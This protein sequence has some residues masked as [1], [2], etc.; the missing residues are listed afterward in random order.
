MSL[1]NVINEIRNIVNKALLDLNYDNINYDISEPP[2]SEFGDL[3]VNVAFLLS[4]RLGKSP[5]KIAQELVNE[6]INIQLKNSNNYSF[7]Q[8]AEAHPSGH[9]NFY[10]NYSNFN[11]FILEIIKKERNLF[12]NLGVKSKITIEHTS[13]NPNKAL[14]IGHLR[15]VVLG[16]SLYR[17]FRE[18]NHEVI[19]LNYIDDS[20]VQVADLIVAFN[21]AGFNSES[22]D[23]SIKFD[24]YCGD[25]YVK[26]N[27]LY[28]TNVDL[29]EKRKLVIK[30]IEKG[31]TEISKFTNSIVEKIV[32]QQLLTCWRIKARYDLLVNESQILLSD[33]WKGTFNLLKQKSIIHF[34]TEGKNLNCWLIND[35]NNEEKVIV[36]SDKT[37][38]YIA[39]DISFA[40]WKLKLVK[41]P[42]IYKQ[43]SIQWDNSILWNTILI[44]ANKDGLINKNNELL[45]LKQ[46][47]TLVIT[48]IDSRQSR[49]QK[50]IT[51]I[52]DKVDITSTKKYIYLGYEAVALSNETVQSIGFE[53]EKINK[54]VIHMSGRKGIFINADMILDELYK[55]SYH[56]VK[57]RNPTWN[58]PIIE[59][60]AEGIAVS[61]IRYNLIKQDL[62]K[63]IT[64]DMKEALNL[65]GDTSLY[66][67]YSYVRGI[68]ILEKGNGFLPNFI[69][70]EKNTDIKL[71]LLNHKTEIE[72]IKEISKFYMII[73]EAVSN[74]NPK[75]I[76]KYANKLSTKFNSF[77]ESL[78][79]LCE[80]YFLKINRLL[81]VKVFVV[82]LSALF[83]I[84]G[85]ETLSRI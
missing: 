84:L 4:K 71:N 69:E 82:I 58:D 39:K 22:L 37:A 57:K 8:N 61:A 54:K 85:I 2:K 25:I 62:D 17:L 76:A 74:L 21:F 47:P 79:V 63:M 65:D 41:D 66:L 28:N 1:K 32:K 29:L 33:L 75:I 81:L 14:H 35:E 34:A 70:I 3:T 16:D 11:K 46:K 15:N 50:I 5:N 42:F 67:Q 44:S 7:I 80:D 73:E 18:T 40:I 26:I 36:R 48:I 51:N 20:G 49:L 12:P 13:V 9:V 45:L 6:S 23:K 43:F 53:L 31:N 72:L 77:Y 64:F 10:I 38:T 30:E 60:T 68:R 56:E 24:Q 27:E 83:E 52:I 78:P 19:V 59:K 55:K